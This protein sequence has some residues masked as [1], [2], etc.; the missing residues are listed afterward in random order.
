MAGALEA[1]RC[2]SRAGSGHGLALRSDGTVWAWGFNG[3]VELGN[4]TTTDPSG[5]V[6]VTGLA[7]A[8]Q[9]AAGGRFSLAVHTVLGVLWS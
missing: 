7:N 8:T 1:P 2:I 4:G 3:S 9:V 5:Q 6:Q